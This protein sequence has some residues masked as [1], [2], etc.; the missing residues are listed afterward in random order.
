MISEIKKEWEEETI[1]MLV[2]SCWQSGL[3]YS[4]YSGDLTEVFLQRDFVTAV[5]CFTVIEGSAPELDSIEKKKILKMLKESRPASNPKK[6]LAIE[7]IYL[8]KGKPLIN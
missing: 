6:A 2:S 8:L 4:E 5:E 3:D 1:R 7:L